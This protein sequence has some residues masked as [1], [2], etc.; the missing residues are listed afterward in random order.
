MKILVAGAQGQLAR[1]LLERYRLRSGFEMIA[2]GR[3]EL[4][5]LDPM[6][7][8]RAVETVRPN[9][10]VNAAAYT[11]VDKAEREVSAAFSVNRDG[12]GALAA[13]AGVHGCPMIHVSTDY[14]FDG[15]K[16]APYVEN[17]ATGPVGAYGRSKLAGEVAVAAANRQHLILRTAWLFSAVGS[18]FLKTIMRLARERPE[19]RVVADQY[20][21]P[22]YAPHLAEA[23][24]D[25][26]AHLAKDRTAADRWGIYH[27]V[28]AGETS[29]HG[30][31]EAIVTAAAPLGVPPVPVIPITSAEYPTP[32]R[33]PANSRL[34]CS[35]LRRAFGIQLP[36]WRDG[37]QECMQLL[38]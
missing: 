32:A 24:L 15:A 37:L 25:I 31:A 13:A 22:T 21:N 27:A 33:R 26:A 38:S 1:A 14:V 28:A 23:I 8:E 7:I 30:F 34:D 4:D 36:D 17:D 5:L 11:A 16:P 9:L 12:A 19:L 20:G 35:K 10:L 3:P 29:W 2:L 6:S 18:N